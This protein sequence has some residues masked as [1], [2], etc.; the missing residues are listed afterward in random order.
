MQTNHSAGDSLS[1]RQRLREFFYARETPYGLAV[2]RMLLPIALLC[3]MVPRWIRARELF[4]IDGAATP[5]WNSYG[6]PHMLPEI[7]GVV[8]VIFASVLIVTLITTSLGWCTRASVLISFV[9]YTYLNML[10]AVSTMTKYSVI[11]SHALLLLSMSHCGAV[12]SID[13]WRRK[14]RAERSGHP[15]PDVNDEHTAQ[16]D[17]AEAPKFP[18]WPRRLMQLMIGYVYFGAAMTKLHTPTYFSSDQL[19]TWLLSNVNYENPVGEYLAL[20][21]AVLVLFAYI[22]IVWE[23]LFVFL[24]WRGW[25]RVCMVGMGTLFHVMTTLMLG[26]YIFPMVCI[27]IYF[28]FLNDNDVSRIR[29]RWKRWTQRWTG[30]GTGRLSP[31]RPLRRLAGITES[32]PVSA[33]VGFVILLTVVATAGV[34]TEYHLDPYGKRRPKGPYTLKELDAD[35]VEG[36]LL[37]RPRALRYKDMVWDFN[38]GTTLVGGVLAFPRKTFRHGETITAQCTL[39]TPHKDMIME[40]HLTDA[41]GHTIVTRRRPAPRELMR[42][43]FAFPITDAF[44]PG[45]YS[46][47]LKCAGV[48]VKRRT[49]HIRPRNGRLAAN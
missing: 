43:S 12:W 30:K 13:A 4:S 10:D 8:A 47:V 3:A 32:L 9:L 20:F 41:E 39:N 37:A 2:V 34:E 17:Y 21:P 31:A 11:A 18:A 40:C 7:P 16:P 46:L 22:A 48:S 19:L 23:I 15:P 44:E 38:A 33:P 35:Y 45:E 49:I 1:L 14:R 5:L 26:L 36:V 29:Q 27:S 28:A 42:L 25:G 6:W 24:C